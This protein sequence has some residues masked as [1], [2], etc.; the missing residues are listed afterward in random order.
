MF[1]SVER[2]N[3]LLR[4]VA[5]L[6]GHHV[7]HRAG[8]F[9]HVRQSA[10]VDAGGELVP[11]KVFDLF[12]TRGFRGERDEADI[13]RAAGHH[14]APEVEVSL[15]QTARFRDRLALER[16]GLVPVFLRLVHNILEKD[17]VVRV[18]DLADG[19]SADEP[20]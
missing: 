8:A 9:V 11:G 16:D 17:R 7:Q 5:R 12:R 3:F 13:I 15:L 18:A 10:D 20:H 6:D 19:R 4:H 14:V 2:R 1:D